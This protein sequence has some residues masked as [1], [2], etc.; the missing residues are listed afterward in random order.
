MSTTNQGGIQAVLPNGTAITY[1]PCSYVVP[2]SY[3]G[4]VEDAYYQIPSGYSLGHY[5]SSWQVP[6]APT[7]NDG[8]TIVLFIGTEDS[9][10]AAILQ[11]VFNW[12]I[13]SYYCTSVCAHTPFTNVNVGDYFNGTENLAYFGCDR[14]N[15]YSII[16]T[17]TNTGGSETLQE[18]AYPQVNIYVTLE[19]YN[20]YQCSDYP[21]AHWTTF[22]PAEIVDNFGNVL[23]PN[24]TPGY[25]NASPNCGFSVSASA[26]DIV[27]FY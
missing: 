24:W 3:S 17:D 19:A 8:Q 16:A 27:L 6:P 9:S 18:C 7:T 26:T 22:S 5:S 14:G 15:P 11:P 25:Y 2:P 4:W 13:A 20:I 10:N 12:Q 21:N 23:S 1:L